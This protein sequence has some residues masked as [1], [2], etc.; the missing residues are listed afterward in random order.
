MKPKKIHN[1]KAT[2]NDA[3]IGK[4]ISSAGTISML[5]ANKKII[6]NTANKNG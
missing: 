1:E 4:I 3:K 6:G 2:N 5:I